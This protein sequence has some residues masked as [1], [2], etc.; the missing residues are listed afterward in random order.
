MC[1]T[2]EEINYKEVDTNIQ[3]ENILT[4]EMECLEENSKKRGINAE[5]E[6]PHKR[7]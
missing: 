7:G 1:D 6:E 2:K 4:R 3:G 5:Y